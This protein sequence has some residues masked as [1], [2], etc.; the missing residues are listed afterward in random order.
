MS[1]QPLPLLDLK[2]VD[3]EK[4]VNENGNNIDKLYDWLSSFSND[5]PDLVREILTEEGLIP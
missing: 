5:F 4:K 2:T 3:V 1:L